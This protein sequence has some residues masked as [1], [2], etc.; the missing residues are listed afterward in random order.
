MSNTD[1]EVVTAASLVYRRRDPVGPAP[2]T[3]TSATSPNTCTDLGIDLMEVRVVADDGAGD[4]HQAL[5]ALRARYT[6]VF[7]T[8]GIGPT[9]DDI[10]AECVAK[11]FGVPIGYRSGSAFEITDRA[12]WRRPARQMNE[13][14][15]AHDPAFRQGAEPR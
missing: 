2:R 1:G 6:Y 7:T 8:G 15:H 13:A 10:T 5:N 3:R 11:A 14:R 4:R 9:H 12:R